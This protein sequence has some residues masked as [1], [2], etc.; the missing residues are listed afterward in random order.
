MNFH[1]LFETFKDKGFLSHIFQRES[2]IFKIKNQIFCFEIEEI[3]RQSFI[4]LNNCSLVSTTNEYEEVLEVIEKTKKVYID[5]THS[6]VQKLSFHNRISD[7]SNQ[8]IENYHR[9]KNRKGR[10]AAKL[11]MKTGNIY[12]IYV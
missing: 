5:G 8:S 3:R 2:S 12:T 6:T 4:H 10:E 7:K 1:T 9:T 11:G